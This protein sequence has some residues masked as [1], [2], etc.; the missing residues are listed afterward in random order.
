MLLDRLLYLRARTGW[1]LVVFDPMTNI[2]S[3]LAISLMEL[4]IAPLPKAI[5]RPATVELCQRRAQ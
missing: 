5:A 2:T 1:F 4:V 3:A